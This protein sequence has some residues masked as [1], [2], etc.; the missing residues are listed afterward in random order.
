MQQ[1]TITILNIFLLLYVNFNKF[2]TGL[3]FLSIFSMLTNFL[4]I[5]KKLITMS[6]IKRLNFKFF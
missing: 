5:K 6:S 4:E 1:M 2:T 3:Y